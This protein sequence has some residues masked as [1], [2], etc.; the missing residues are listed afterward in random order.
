MA[1]WTTILLPS[2][3]KPGQLDSAL[4]DTMGR[5][6]GGENTENMRGWWK[7][8]H[9]ENDRTVGTLRTRVLS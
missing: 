5:R 4:E 8:V 3:P 6:S 2:T 1:P 9:P 7:A